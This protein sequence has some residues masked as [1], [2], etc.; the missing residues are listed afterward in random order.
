MPVCP[1]SSENRTNAL[2][3]IL[4]AQAEFPST[5]TGAQPL[6]RFERKLS[7]STALSRRGGHKGRHHVK[8]SKWRLGP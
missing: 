2:V 6:D 7:R 3:S 4:G 1:P 5:H 8:C